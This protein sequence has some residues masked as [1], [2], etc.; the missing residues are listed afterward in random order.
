MLVLLANAVHCV[1]HSILVAPRF[2]A[3]A[4]L[5]AAPISVLAS[6]LICVG[7][8]QGPLDAV[9]LAWGR[10]LLAARRYPQARAHL[11][12]APRRRAPHAY[13]ETAVHVGDPQQ[14]YSKEDC[15]ALKLRSA[16]ERYSCYLSR[17]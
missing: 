6:L 8:W 2:S 11:R 15:S 3:F 10:A 16:L 5:L 4:L 7:A 1:F 9:E 13:V 14:E 17:P 12:Y